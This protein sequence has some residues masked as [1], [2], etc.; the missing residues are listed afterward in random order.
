MT[1]LW[2]V[3]T[4]ETQGKTTQQHPRDL[5]TVSHPHVRNKISI[6]RNYGVTQGVH[7]STHL[8]FS[9]I[10]HVY[11]FAQPGE[12]LLFRGLGSLESRFGTTQ[13]ERCISSTKVGMVRIQHMGWKATLWKSLCGKIPVY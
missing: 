7:W 4:H 8:E 12:E 13:M 10:S 3:T 6:R 2:C 9:F 1:K 11:S 5:S